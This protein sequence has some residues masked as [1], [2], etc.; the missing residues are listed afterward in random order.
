[1][2]DEPDPTTVDGEVEML[3]RA[4]LFR[5]L[6][7]RRL[8]LLAFTGQTRLFRAGEAVFRQ[9]EPGDDAFLLLAGTVAVTVEAEQDSVPIAELGSNDLIGEIAVLCDAPRTATVTATTDVRALRIEKD[10]LLR[11]M[12]EFPDMALEV[13]RALAL[14]LERTT[15][16][17]ASARH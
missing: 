16:A 15:R 17:L 2:M 10:T 12:R 8:R 5:S 14:R 4:P 13:M 6:D 7:T 3:R 9:G 11:L 1:M